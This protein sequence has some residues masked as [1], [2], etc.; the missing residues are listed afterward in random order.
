MAKITVTVADEPSRA[1]P[2]APL[3]IL[4]METHS[5]DL[6]TARADYHLGHYRNPMSD[7]DQDEKLRAMARDYAGLPDSRIDRLLE[8]LRRLEQ[9][10]DVGAVLALTAAR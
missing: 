6:L 8:R 9:V 10:E 2:E 3:H 1:W 4:E 5:G 7:A